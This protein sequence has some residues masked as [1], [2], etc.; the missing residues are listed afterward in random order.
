[1]N[2]RRRVNSTVGR[3]LK[4]GNNCY[5][6]TPIDFVG[7]LDGNGPAEFFSTGSCP[8]FTYPQG[9]IMTDTVWAAIV[10]GIAGVVTGSISAVV[11]PWANWGI[12]KRRQ[13]D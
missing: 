9:Q 4:I 3:I 11:A 7:G 6:T 12:E 2:S 13:N 5:A 10:G 1:M 8:T